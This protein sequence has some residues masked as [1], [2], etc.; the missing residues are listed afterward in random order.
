MPGC[1]LCADMDW[2]WDWEDVLGFWLYGEGFLRDLH[3]KWQKLDIFWGN[4]GMYGTILWTESARRFAGIALIV[5]ALDTVRDAGRLR[6][7]IPLPV[8]PGHTEKAAL[9]TVQFC[10][11]IVSCVSGF[12]RFGVLREL[13]GGCIFPF[14]SWYS[15]FCPPYRTSLVTS[16]N[17]FIMPFRWRLYYDGCRRSEMYALLGISGDGAYFGIL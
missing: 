5:D 7:I 17:A 3:W 9:L 14:H 8:P 6:D 12:L 11:C 1:V 15:I 16:W 2:D 10:C 4:V 13:C